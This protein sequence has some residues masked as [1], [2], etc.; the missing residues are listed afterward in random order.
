MLYHG[1][2]KKDQCATDR[3]TGPVK[4]EKSTKKAVATKNFSVGA[5]KKTA[6][7]PAARHD[8]RNPT[9]RNERGE[10]QPGNARKVPKTKYDPI[11]PG[12]GYGQFSISSRKL[13]RERSAHSCTGMRGSFWLRPSSRRSARTRAST[14]S[15]PVSFRSFRLPPIS[16]RRRSPRSERNPID[17][18]L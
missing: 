8:R 18:V 5:R 9:K 7:P 1:R 11:A 10:I 3:Q 4:A 15:L 14:W 2:L 17:G 16:P 13:I 12:T 6:S